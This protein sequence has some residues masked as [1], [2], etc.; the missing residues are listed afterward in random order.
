MALSIYVSYVYCPWV[1]RLA[2]IFLFR[3]KEKIWFKLFERLLKENQSIFASMVLRL[4]NAF[5]PNFMHR[6]SARMAAKKGVYAL[7]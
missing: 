1:W 4:D 5:S 3:E 7:P 2:K 6:R